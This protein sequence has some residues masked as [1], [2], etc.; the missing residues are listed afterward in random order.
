LQGSKVVEIR[1][2]GV[3]KGT[4]ALY[5]LHDSEFDFILALGDDWTDEDL[6]GILPESAYSM[7]VGM[8]LSFARF[9]LQT[10]TDA[11]FLLKEL[12]ECQ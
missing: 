5:F 1:S 3:N 12:T 10:Y 6:F 7:R 9:N 8:H 11:I 4:A 2:A